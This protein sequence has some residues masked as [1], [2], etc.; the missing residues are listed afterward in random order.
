MTIIRD[1]PEVEYHA[2]PALSSTGARRL[3][4]APAVYHYWRNNPEP[5]KEEF[6][7]GTLVHSKV[8]G[9]GASIDVIPD[10]ILASNGAMSTKAAKEFVAESRA[11]GRIPMRS[12]QARQVDR[13]AESVL[14]HPTARAF[15]EAGGDRELSV[16]S[17]DPATGV[18]QRARFDLMTGETRQGVFAVDLKTTEGSASLPAFTRTV[19]N[20]GYH[21]Q[22]TWYDEVARAAG[23]DPFRFLFIVVEKKP[24]Y[25]VGLT[26]LSAKWIEMGRE[27]TARARRVF[28]ECTQSG[29][30]PGLPEDVQLSEPPTYI[31]MQHEEQ[32]TYEHA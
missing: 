20:Y 24:P 14:K 32:M 1:M 25:M 10:E 2:H 7:I 8:L 29:V 21:I 12:G 9:V 22:E 28:A 6:D 26:I 11:A 3:L 15:L 30:W 13:I 27:S 17:K 31:V 19:G 16:F 18:E 4:E 5:P 23:M